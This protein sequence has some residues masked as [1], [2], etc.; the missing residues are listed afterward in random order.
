MFPLDNWLFIWYYHINYLVVFL[1]SGQRKNPLWGLR[2]SDIINISSKFFWT[3]I[4]ENTNGSTARKTGRY[5][6]AHAFPTTTPKPWA[7]SCI[8][9]DERAES[10]QV[11]CKL[12]YAPH[13]FCLKSG[14]RYRLYFFRAA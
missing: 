1:K 10:R 4:F 11:F 13:T 14:K 5:I 3:W 6:A 9:L 7:L 2:N 8:I 12:R